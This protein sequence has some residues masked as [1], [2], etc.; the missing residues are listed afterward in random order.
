MGGST[1]ASASGWL[2]GSGYRLSLRGDAELKNLYR[3]A[4]ALDLSGFR[5]VAEGA[6]RLD[7]NVSGI[8]QGPAA[9]PQIIGA[10]QLS[11][12]HTGMRGLNPEIDLTSGWLKVGPDAVSLEKSPPASARRSGQVL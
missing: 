7:V 4:N 2:S 5:P 3:L 1:P 12:V 11:N 10:A 6:A 8:W 9:P